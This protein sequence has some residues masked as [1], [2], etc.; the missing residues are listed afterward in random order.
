[1]LREDIKQLNK[2]KKEKELGQTEQQTNEE[3]NKQEEMVQQ[4]R[5]KMKRT[6]RDLQKMDRQLKE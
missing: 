3:I 1:M 4:P 2:E 6:W 5:K